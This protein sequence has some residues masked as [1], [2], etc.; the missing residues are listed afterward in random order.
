LS[1]EAGIFVC[2]VGPSGA[3][4]D[5]LLRRVQARLAA[6]PGFIFPQRRVTRSA[7]AHEEHLVLSESDYAEGVRA[8]RF[9]LAWRAHGLGY[10]IDSNVL[11]ALATGYIVTCNVSRD[12][13]AAAKR[14]FPHIAT[15]L[16]TAP[17]EVLA[18]RLAARGRETPVDIGERLARNREFSE[19]FAVD[20]VVDNSGP[21]P[22]ATDQLAAILRALAATMRRAAPPA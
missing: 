2:L 15:I 19:N 14:N 10:A 5:T 7:S 6:E 20:F 9:A 1:A 17:A 3:G 13:I 22:V 12:A 16:V 4:K 8:G 18:M 21:L 11:L